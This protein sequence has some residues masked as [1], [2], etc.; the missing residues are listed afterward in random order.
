[1]IGNPFNWFA[2]LRAFVVIVNPVKFLGAVARGQALSDVVVRTPVGNVRLHLR[3]YESLKTCF[4]VFCRRDYA[5]P[6]DP[7]FAFLDVGANIGFASIYFLSR[8]RANRV[9]C[10]EPDR[11]NLDFLKQN[12]HDF[13][14]R[15]EIRGYALATS[16]GTVS[17]FRAED[18]KYSSLIPSEK[19]CLP[20]RIECRVFA[21]ALREVA[22]DSLPVVV[23]LDVEGLEL[24]LVRS[25]EWRE[26]PRV[27]RLLCESTECGQ[28][29]SRAHSRRVRNGYVEDVTFTDG[30]EPRRRL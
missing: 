6:T 17:L 1:V 26:F 15:S 27:R 11:A 9:T 10:F 25:V 2:L 21:D 28:V 8:N 20:D 7:P 23:K 24:D 4:S 16:T 22:S 30:A 13:A 3:N 19:A 18:G 29:I 5:T 14:D 12:L